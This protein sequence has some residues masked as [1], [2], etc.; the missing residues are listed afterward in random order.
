MVV[1]KLHE[2]TPKLFTMTWKFSVAHLLSYLYFITIPFPSGFNSAQT[3]SSRV[4]YDSKGIGGMLTGLDHSHETVTHTAES[5]QSSCKEVIRIYYIPEVCWM[6]LYYTTT[7]VK[8][9]SSYTT[10]TLRFNWVFQ[11]TTP[12]ICFACN[13]CLSQQK[14]SILTAEYLKLN[15]YRIAGNFRWSKFL[16][17]SRFPSRRNFRGFNFRI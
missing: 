11:Q 4:G 12:P 16:R 2:I 1:T 9:W 14:W 3:M 8:S 6:L 7:E 15:C 13:M 10:C 5:K 17:K